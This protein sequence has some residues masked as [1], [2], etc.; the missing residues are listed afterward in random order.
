MTANWQQ[1]REAKHTLNADAVRELIAT[2]GGHADI[3]A[4][5]WSDWQRAVCAEA[6]R[7]TVAAAGS[8]MLVHQPQRVHLPARIMVGLKGHEGFARAVIDDLQRQGW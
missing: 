7:K 8:Q 2:T 5:M 6:N 4:V 1:W 3:A